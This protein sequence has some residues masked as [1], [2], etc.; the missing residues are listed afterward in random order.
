[1]AVVLKAVPLG[2]PRGERQ[3]RIEA[4][5][6]LDGGLLIH[7]ENSCMLRRMQV[8]TNNV[9]GLLLEVR[10]IRSHI[11]IQPVG[12]EAVLAPHARDHHMRD[13]QV[14][15]Q[16]T[17]APLCRAIRRLTLH[18]P[19]QNPSLQSWSERAGLLTGMATEKPR[20]TLL[21]KPLAPAIDEGVTAGQFAAN[22]CPRITL[23]KQQNQ[24]CTARVIRSP[25]LARRSL[26]E[27]YVF[28]LRQ[29]DR[30]HGAQSYSRFSR[31]SPLVDRRKM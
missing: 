11:A 4:I 14:L 24:A 3:D 15:G 5:Q 28:F 20:Q 1:M 2:P 21:P 13:T 17:G 29:F 31:Y 25:G 18:R 22:L 10:V 19:F 7:A 23:L 6:S 16:L 27:F 12:L 8:Q 26:T 30:A 9:R